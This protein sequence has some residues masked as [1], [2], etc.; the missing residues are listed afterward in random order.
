MAMKNVSKIVT[1]VIL[2]L[3]GFCLG[4]STSEKLKKEQKA[5]E[6]KLASTQLLLNKTKSN[7]E[8]SL[9]EL[10]ILE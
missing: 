8:A 9:S 6:N 4:Q 2:L 10:K 1:I 7:T 3:S 5:L